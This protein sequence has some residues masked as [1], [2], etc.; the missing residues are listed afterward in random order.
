MAAEE[1]ASAF[2][3]LS[4]DELLRYGFAGGLFLIVLGTLMGSI[5]PLIE[6]GAVEAGHAILLGAGAI[7]I[8]SFVYSVHRLLLFPR[9]RRCILNR[10]HKEL[11]DERRTRHLP[12]HQTDRS[13]LFRQTTLET[14]FDVAR[15]G[16]REREDGGYTSGP[17]P[18]WSRWGAQIHLMFTGSWA[19]IAAMVAAGALSLTGRSISV[20]PLVFWLG[21]MVVFL[22]AGCAATMRINFAEAHLFP[23][24]AP[25]WWRRMR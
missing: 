12:P 4:L 25:R 7:L 1:S 22:L 13:S 20:I 17:G 5:V 23:W 16:R 18:G 10:I 21:A 9:I 15:W 6:L 14:E 24:G 19:I 3:S 8:G 11:G 2:P